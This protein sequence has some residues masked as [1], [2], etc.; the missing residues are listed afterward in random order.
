MKCFSRNVV[1]RRVEKVLGN[2]ALASLPTYLLKHRTM[3]LFVNTVSFYAT[4]LL[5]LLRVNAVGY[6]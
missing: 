2:N 1:V 4:R 5:L 3:L 6:M